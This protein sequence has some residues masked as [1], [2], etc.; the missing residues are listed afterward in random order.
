MKCLI[1]D[2]LHA[3]IEPL[4]QGIG[5]P[6]DYRPDIK[7]EEVHACI[8]GYEGLL[9]RSKMKITPELLEKAVRL[10]FIAR[11]G[12]GVDEI[13]EDYLRERGITLI[14]A[15]EGN[16]DAVG[17]H[18]LGM[19]LCLFN[20]IN[21]GDAEVRRKLW[22]REANRGL[23]IKGRVIGLIGYGNMGKAFAQRLSGFGCEVL[24]FDKYKLY[25]G[26]QFGRE[27]TLE[28]L[29]ERADVL[30]LH[31]PLTPETNGM[32][33]E[34]FLS[35]FRKPIHLVNTARGPIVP[36]EGLVA[37]MKAGKV[38]GAA[39]DVLENE[40]L[41]TLTPAQAQAFEWLAAQPNV[42]F[43]PHV[44][45]WTYESYERLNAVMVKKIALLRDGE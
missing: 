10:R 12:A 27:A 8:G 31:T 7:P 21:L 11:A 9:L 40:R 29:F 25:Y 28:E 36:L 5:M 1:I 13:S 38:A 19:L 2:E 32:V 18:A 15:P 6:Y 33:N 16:R 43:T 35:S 4:L 45:G 39:L 3:S 37:A 34:A 22:R 20:K 24:A 14:N 44:G 26:N 30:S 41:D 42:L 23:E 17:E